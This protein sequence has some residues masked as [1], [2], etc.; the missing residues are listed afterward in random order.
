MPIKSLPWW[1]ETIQDL[2]EDHLG[3]ILPWVKTMANL[4]RENTYLRAWEPILWLTKGGKPNV[5]R[6]TFR[7]EDDKDSLIG[8]S[9]IGEVEAQPLRKAHPTPRPT[10]LVE[11]FLVRA[12]EPG[13]VV[14]D[15]MV[16]SGTTASV[17]RRLGRQCVGYD[18]NPD[19]PRMASRWLAQTVANPEEAQ[20]SPSAYRQA[21]L[22]V[23]WEAE[24]CRRPGGPFAG[25]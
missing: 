14:L 4:H 25:E 18:I 2:W 22:L 12:S 19:Y 17:A 9:A 16:G 1:L 13:M 5:L 7:F 24:E 20:E 8:L 11:Y 3:H 10:W 21:E 23:R 6:R 15:P